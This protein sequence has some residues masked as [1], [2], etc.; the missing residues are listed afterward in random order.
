MSPRFAPVQYHSP[1]IWSVKLWIFGFGETKSVLHNNAEAACRFSRLV[2]DVEKLGPN[3]DKSVRVIRS[4]DWQK[5]K[6][7]AVLIGSA[8]YAITPLTGVFSRRLPIG[9]VSSRLFPVKWRLPGNPSFRKS[10]FLS[11]VQSADE[12][13]LLFNLLWHL[14]SSEIMC[15][16][17]N[18]KIYKYV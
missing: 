4:P 7:S 10:T 8:P 6:A 9:I 17:S 1:E 13:S 18:G 3:V 14:L 12:K 15:R 2:P 16:F 11:N 5:P